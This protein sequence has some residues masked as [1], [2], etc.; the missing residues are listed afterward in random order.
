MLLY[1]VDRDPTSQSLLSVFLIVLMKMASWVSLVSQCVSEGLDK[2][3][4][5]DQSTGWSFDQTCSA[6]ADELKSASLIA[7]LIVFF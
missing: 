4:T 7:F 1:S 3:V 6:N 2:T 5:P